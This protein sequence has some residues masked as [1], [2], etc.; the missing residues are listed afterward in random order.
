MF[1]SDLLAEGM[2]T[3][4]RKKG[5]LRKGDRLGQ[6]EDELVLKALD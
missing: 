1:L 3:W 6:N 4:R 5:D 2:E